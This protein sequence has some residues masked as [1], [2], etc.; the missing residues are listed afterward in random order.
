[1]ERKKGNITKATDLVTKRPVLDPIRLLPPILT[2]QIRIIRVPRPIAVLD[3]RQRLIQRARP[4]VQTEVGLHVR[5]QHREP[6][7]ELVGAELIR[8]GAQPGEF[9]ARGT[10]GARADAV[11]PV[12]GCDE[13]PAWV[14][15]YR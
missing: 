10:V 4:K 13:V 8:L 3:P 2:P 7:H 14:A 5:T 15:D 9:G 12:V 1:M 6:V 11:L